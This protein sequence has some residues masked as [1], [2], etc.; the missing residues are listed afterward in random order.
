MEKL[1]SLNRDQPINSKWR[2]SLLN[3]RS[4]SAVHHRPREMATWQHSS[5]VLLVNTL[6]LFLTGECQGSDICMTHLHSH[7]T[8]QGIELLYSDFFFGNY[9]YN[10]HRK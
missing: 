10:D 1:Q 4:N 7:C 6:A 9:S 8:S 3:L 5:L 2:E